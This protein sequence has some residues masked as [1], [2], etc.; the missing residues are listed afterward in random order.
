MS[1]NIRSSVLETPGWEQMML[2]KALPGYLTST[3]AFSDAGALSSIMLNIHL[4]IKYLLVLHLAVGVKTVWVKIFGLVSNEF[5]LSHAG[6]LA[7]WICCLQLVAGWP[8]QAQPRGPVVCS[9]Q[10]CC[11]TYF[12]LCCL[13][14]RSNWRIA[15][16]SLEILKKKSLHIWNLMLSF[17][18]IW[19]K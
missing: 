19:S 12:E 6:R 4:N 17:L 16:H 5:T 15:I 7:K 8:W 3:L 13:N 10:S 1:W 11:F 14:F 9:L 2:I 18:R